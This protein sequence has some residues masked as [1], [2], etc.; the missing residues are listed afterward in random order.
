MHIK[1][2]SI[3]ICGLRK[4]YRR[5]LL[6]RYVYYLRHTRFTCILL[7]KQDLGSEFDIS[8]TLSL[9]TWH[10][11]FHCSKTPQMASWYLWPISRVIQCKMY[12]SVSPSRQRSYAIIVKVC[13]YLYI[14]T[15]I[16][17]EYFMQ[18]YG[19]TMSYSDVQLVSI[20][21]YVCLCF[22]V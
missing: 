14:I 20:H 12:N 1:P 3:C 5:V 6:N 4:K 17:I 21:M 13:S 15:R 19:N 9:F 8:K 2:G 11:F 7:L 22:S 10:H 18:W 16:L